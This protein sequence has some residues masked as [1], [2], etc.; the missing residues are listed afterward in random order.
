MQSFH[1]M[2]KKI[3]ETRL[4][5]FGT[6]LGIHG[7]GRNPPRARGSEGGVLGLQHN[8]IHRL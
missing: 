8:R 7:A 6:G 1:A 2:V 4:R 5:D 3:A